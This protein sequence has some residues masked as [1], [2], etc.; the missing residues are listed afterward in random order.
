MAQ[1]SPLWRTACTAPIAVRT[2]R[3]GGTVNR[4]PPSADARA[5]CRT[6]VQ[7]VRTA[8]VRGALP[9]FAV[10]LGLSATEWSY[11][12]T[13]LGDGF[14]GATPGTDPAVPAAAEAPHGSLLTLL[15]SFR[16]D[17]SPAC[18][19]AAA[20]VACGC[21]GRQHLWQ[22][23][24]LTGRS[25]VTALLQA[26]FPA[27]VAQNT[28]GLKWKRF[29]FLKLGEQLG[30]PD[31]QPPHCSGCDQYATCYPPAESAIAWPPHT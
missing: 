29:L 18:W 10:R 13:V 6:A 1:R 4:T 28:Q 24:G 14:M 7:H 23:L 5:L 26:Y 19:V 16:T 2:L 17:A 20:A 25:D 3:S 27:L 15:W 11:L 22:D 12:T 21:L 9:P 30:Q 31:L 8:A